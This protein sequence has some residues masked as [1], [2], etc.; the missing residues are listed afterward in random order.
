LKGLCQVFLNNQNEYEVKTECTW[1]EENQGI[2][3]I[4]YEDGKFYNQTTLTEIRE[5]LNKIV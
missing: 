3:H 5:R 2:M 4:I 1:I